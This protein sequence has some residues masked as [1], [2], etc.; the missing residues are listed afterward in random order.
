MQASTFLLSINSA[1][2]ESTRA[3]SYARLD[4]NL[5]ILS[6]SGRLALGSGTLVTACSSI[7]SIRQRVMTV[8]TT[9]PVACSSLPKT[10]VQKWPTVASSWL[11]ATK[12]MKDGR[13]L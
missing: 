9:A 1:R 6:I 11:D 3:C 4:T 2:E 13:S 7:T 5:A 10:R 12:L 8:Q